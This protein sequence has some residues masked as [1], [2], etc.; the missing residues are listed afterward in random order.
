MPIRHRRLYV[1]AAG[2][3][4]ILPLAGLA[5]TFAQ[6]AV[7]PA[8]GMSTTL[9]WPSVLLTL[10][11]AILGVAVMWGT[12][13]ERVN[14]HTTEIRELWDKQKEFITRRE[15]DLIERANA[16]AGGGGVVVVAAAA[17][18]V[19]V[20]NATEKRQEAAHQDMV[21]LAASMIAA[22]EGIKELLARKD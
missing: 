13:R 14:T 4:V 10:F 1:S 15:C 5:Y 9:N 11:G 6:G 22:T 2:L 12:F 16:G 20:A 18:A 7:A 17:A 8:G 19:T 3:A 21:G